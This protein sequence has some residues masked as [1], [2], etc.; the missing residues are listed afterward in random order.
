MAPYSTLEVHSSQHVD[1]TVQHTY[2]AHSSRYPEVAPGH[3]PDY[4]PEVVPQENPK[5]PV[6]VPVEMKTLLHIEPGKEVIEHSAP[7]AVNGQFVGLG[8]TSPEW[9]Q[10][11]N[12]PGQGTKRICGLRRR[13]FWT[14]I[15]IK[16]I[17]AVVIATTLG[18]ILTRPSNNNADAYSPLTNA[19]AATNILSNSSLT[20]INF[21][22][23]SGYNHRMVFFEDGYNAIVARRWDSQNTTWATSNL[24]LVMSNSPTA[25]EIAP[26]AAL[27]AAGVGH[28]VE[29]FLVDAG[30]TIRSLYNGDVLGGPDHWQNYTMNATLV[31]YPGSRLAATAQACGPDDTF[32]SCAL[33]F[34]TAGWV[35]A[36]Q[37]PGDGALVTTNY[38][39]AWAGRQLAVNG[40]D[41]AAATSLALVTQYQ[42]D[43]AQM[44]LLSEGYVSGT[45]GAVQVANYDNHTWALNDGTCVFPLCAARLLE[46]LHAR[47]RGCPINRVSE[48]H[49]DSEL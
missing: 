41:T 34:C 42:G 4:Y 23:S 20:A 7:E 21:T 28:Q 46:C 3:Q 26:G 31:A 49:V 11:T 39:S 17:V 30:N 1:G 9:V 37:Q 18:V 47:L 6:L 33:D 44:G 12:A 19:T 13:W 29:L 43:T 10:D 14:I 45:E 16:V 15:A 8:S 40:I 27:A 25:V 24:T 2:H 38:S 32:C 5:Y 35:V 22:D 48:F 36:F